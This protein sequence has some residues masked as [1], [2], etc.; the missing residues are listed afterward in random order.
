[1]RT[2]YCSVGGEPN[3]I[4][5]TLSELLKSDSTTYSSH[6][7]AAAQ[8]VDAAV[9]LDQPLLIHYDEVGPRTWQ[10]LEV[11]YSFVNEIWTEMWNVNRKGGDMPLIFFLVTGKTIAY[12]RTDAPSNHSH[13]PVGIKLR[14]LNM[15]EPTHVGEIRKHLQECKTPLVLNVVTDDVAEYLDQSLCIVT[16]GAPRLLLYTL[17][18][19]HFACVNDGISLHS[20]AN[21]DQAIHKRAFDLINDGLNFGQVLVSSGLCGKNGPK[22]CKEL[23]LLLALS[24]FETSLHFETF[25]QVPGGPRIAAGRFFTSHAFV[26]TH[27]SMYG[28]EAFVL[29]LPLYH[30]RAM[31]RHLVGILP[32]LL[33]GMAAAA[34]HLDK[35]WRIF[36]VLPAD[37]AAIRASLSHPFY[38]ATWA[39]VIPQWF[40]ASKLAGSMQFRLRKNPFQMIVIDMAATFQKQRLFGNRVCVRKRKATSSDEVHFMRPDETKTASMLHE[41]LQLG[42]LVCELNK[43]HCPVHVPVVVCIVAGTLSV[44]LNSFVLSQIGRVLVLTSWGM[45]AQAEFALHETGLLWHRTGQK[46]WYKWP[47]KEKTSKFAGKLTDQ[48]TLIAVRPNLE[49]VIPHPDVVQELVSPSL[50][51]GLI[52]AQQTKDLSAVA[53]IICKLDCMLSPQQHPSILNEFRNLHDNIT[54]MEAIKM[55]AEDSGITD[56]SWCQEKVAALSAHDILTVG[57]LRVL[58]A[59]SI[60]KLNPSAL[61]TGYLRHIHS[62]G[63]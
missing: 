42:D 46:K 49:V 7:V 62:G 44:G 59:A 31:G 9:K 54:M 6:R 63:I 32:R 29:T 45:E 28:H 39:S 40:G 47:G 2:V 61:L 12:V 26:L 58:R 17:R 19:L 48:M 36:G 16:G 60:E 35:P 41:G 53:S 33:A 24:L 15:F 37:T 43:I 5:A 38:T 30:L 20:K 56:E 57:N 3:F 11:L 51:D 21:I 1:M 25:V 52:N 34:I 8:V 13:Y 22:T 14:V 10:D 27:C 18:A 50:F 23:A 4:R 55:I